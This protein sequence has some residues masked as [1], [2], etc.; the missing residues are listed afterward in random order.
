MK[1]AWC[2]LQ[3]SVISN[4]GSGIGDRGSDQDQIGMSGSVVRNQKGLIP[5]N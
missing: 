5:D 1:F 4:Q 2:G 3:G